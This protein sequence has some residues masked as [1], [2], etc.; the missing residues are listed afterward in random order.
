MPRKPFWGHVRRQAVQREL[1]VRLTELTLQCGFE[2]F[3]SE[4][5]V[6]N[7]AKILPTAQLKEFGVEFPGHL[8]L[9]VTRRIVIAECQQEPAGG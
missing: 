1:T 6:G 2:E 7:E 9:G 4:R 5:P 3:D 8:Q